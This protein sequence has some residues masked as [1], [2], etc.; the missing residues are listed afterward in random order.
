MNRPLTQK[1]EFNIERGSLLF[2][3]V[4]RGLVPIEHAHEIVGIR[5]KINHSVSSAVA[6]S[7]LELMFLLPASEALV[8]M[9]SDF[10]CVEGQVDLA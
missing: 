7:G 8:T 9:D 6:H 5:R 1:D 3:V 10:G 4:I 2:K